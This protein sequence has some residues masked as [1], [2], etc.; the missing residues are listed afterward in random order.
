MELV[1][2]SMPCLPIRFANFVSVIKSE[3][4]LL[5]AS[6]TARDP[7]ADKAWLI[8]LIILVSSR[9]SSN[10]VDKTMVAFFAVPEWAEMRAIWL[11][12]RTVVDRGK[13]LTRQ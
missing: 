6:I 1:I 13:D 12:I 2:G 10:C 8:G 5:M 4:D 7:S 9:P 11:R 3:P